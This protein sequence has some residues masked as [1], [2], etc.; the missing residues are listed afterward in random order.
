MFRKELQGY[1]NAR[2]AKRIEE[3]EAPN[4]DQSN[5][6]TDLCLT[7]LF[8]SILGLSALAVCYLVLLTGVAYAIP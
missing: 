5:E 6:R 4:E 3:M 2:I 8:G 7:C 1:Q